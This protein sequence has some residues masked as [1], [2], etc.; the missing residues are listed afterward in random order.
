MEAVIRDVARNMNFTLSLVVP[1]YNE[2]EMCDLFFSRVIP[3]SSRVTR[4]YEIV[5]VNDGRRDETHAALLQEHTREPRIKIVNLPRNFYKE[6]ALTAG[7]GYATGGVVIPTDA[8]LQDPPELIHAGILCSICR[9]IHGA[10]LLDA[11]WLHLFRQPASRF[12]TIRHR[13]RGRLCFN[14]AI[15]VVVNVSD[16]PYHF[17]VALMVTLVPLVIFLSSRHWAFA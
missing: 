16:L 8:D 9:W 15:N 1:M 13:V 4:N 17:V 10:L 7:I 6:L 5:C 12:V 3:I 11:L 14:A 2:T